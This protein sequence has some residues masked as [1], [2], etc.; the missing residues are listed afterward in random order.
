MKAAQIKEYG[1]ASVITINEV[2]RPAPTA[3]QVLVEVHAS[4]LNPFDSSVR[5]G[6]MKEV[7]KLH[8]PATLGGDIAGVITEVGEGVTSFDVGEKIYGQANVV[9]GN[10]GA[11]AEYAATSAGQIAKMPE[12]LDFQQAASLPLVGVS[13]LQ[14]LLQHID[15][16]AGQKIFINGGAGGIGTVAIQIAKHKGAYVATTATGTGIDDVRRLGANE[17]IDYTTKDF[18]EVLKDYDA[19]FDTVGGET[20]DKALTILKPGSIAVSMV[21]H[22]DEAKAQRLDVIAIH[23]QTRVTTDSLDELRRLIEDGIVTSHIDKTFSIDHI[24][25]AFEARESGTIRGKVVIAVT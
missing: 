24:R 5:S 20:F 7:I 4:S 16:Q 2:D 12:N 6:Y 8:F 11:F 25:D 21:A 19:V 3:G 13:A 15:I 18:A 1:D 22:V 14:A 23:Q 9:A 10:S 17:V